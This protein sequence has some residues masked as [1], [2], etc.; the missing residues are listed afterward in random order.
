MKF[1]KD[2]K[3]FVY[4][5][6]GYENV[7]VLCFKLVSP[8]SDNK[9]YVIGWSTVAEEDEH[10]FNKKIGKRIAENRADK[11]LDVMYFDP[12]DTQGRETLFKIRRVL[13]VMMYRKI[14]QVAK[15][16]AERDYYP[17]NEQLL[18]PLFFDPPKVDNFVCG[19]FNK[20][21]IGPDGDV[22]TLQAVDIASYTPRFVFMEVNKKRILDLSSMD[23]V[24]L[25]FS[26]GVKKDKE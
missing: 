14:L 13:S 12:D 22:Y 18:A 5:K 15:F 16:L 10:K 21:L 4:V 26:V 1:D 25:F 17:T 3:L 24:C 2:G 23:D 7:G 11:I 9:Q 19:Y 6:R 20:P 8:T